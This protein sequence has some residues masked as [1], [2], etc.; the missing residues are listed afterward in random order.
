MWQARFNLVWI[1]GFRLRVQVLQLKHHK[2]HFTCPLILQLPMILE[3]WSTYG[4]T[5]TL[6]CACLYTGVSTE[7]QCM[8]GA[9]FDQVTS[10]CL[11]CEFV[12]HK[13][14]HY[15]CRLNCPKEF[16][17]LTCGDTDRQTF[18]QKTLE[19]DRLSMHTDY[20]VNTVPVTMMN[21]EPGAAMMVDCI[22]LDTAEAVGTLIASIIVALI[23]GFTLGRYKDLKNYYKGCL[24]GKAYTVCMHCT[25]LLYITCH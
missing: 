24:N 12:C 23:V 6:L 10:L 4:L 21:I 5:V 13:P 15:E 11:S 25:E 22:G 3:R 17:Q 8:D 7:R 19:I 14:D 9:Y 2:Q 16:C 18:C 1:F 20:A